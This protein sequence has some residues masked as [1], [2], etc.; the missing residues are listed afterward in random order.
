MGLLFA[1]A[2]LG[3][4]LAYAVWDLYQNQQLPKLQRPGAQQEK[5]TEVPEAGPSGSHS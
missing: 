1:F 2:L 4:P 3:I 5:T